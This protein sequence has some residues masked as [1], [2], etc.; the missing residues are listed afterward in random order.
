MCLSGHHGEYKEPHKNMLEFQQLS[1]ARDIS[2]RCSFAT[3]LLFH[4]LPSVARTLWTR[5]LADMNP[6]QLDATAENEL[7]GRV[8]HS[9][10]ADRGCASAAVKKGKTCLKPRIK[11]TGVRLNLRIE[12]LSCKPISTLA[13]VPGKARRRGGTTDWK[14][15]WK[16]FCQAQLSGPGET[17][18]ARN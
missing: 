15:G 13:A 14:N 18:C 10:T 2:R 9:S 6:P 17:A 8:P 1:L 11:S 12:N 16:D 3:C 4:S 7:S 5:S